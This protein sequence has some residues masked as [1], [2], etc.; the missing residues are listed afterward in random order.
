VQAV[1]SVTGDSIVQQLLQCLPLLFRQA[2]ASQ[3]L[4]PLLI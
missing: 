2:D 3:N 1:G 4:L